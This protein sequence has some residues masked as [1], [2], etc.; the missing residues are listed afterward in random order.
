MTG[1]LRPPAG[2][3]RPYEFPAT[4]RF[5]LGNGLRVVVAPMPRLPLVSILAVVDAGAAGDCPG[6]EGLAMLTA[7]ALAE[8]AAGRDGPA[9]AEAFERLGTGIETGAGWDDTT[10]RLTVTPASVRRWCWR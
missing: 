2:V 3:A 9:L 5:A 1:A 10:V 8:G 4:T 7:M 6:R